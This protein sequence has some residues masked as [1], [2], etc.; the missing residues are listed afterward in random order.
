M[1]PQRLYKKPQWSCQ[2]GDGHEH[3][4][5]SCKKTANPGNRFQRKYINMVISEAAQK[6]PSHRMTK[7]ST[8]IL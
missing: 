3:H 6:S 1:L 2:Y 4:G 7:H 5:D 8:H